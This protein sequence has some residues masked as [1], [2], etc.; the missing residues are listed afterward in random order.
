MKEQTLTEKA[1]AAMES[2]VRKV[3]VDHKQRNRPLAV[4]QDDKVVMLSPESA[5]MVHERPVK[6]GEE[7]RR[8]RGKG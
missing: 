6:Y 5:L 4:W 3:I 8:M 1:V 7:G 2:A